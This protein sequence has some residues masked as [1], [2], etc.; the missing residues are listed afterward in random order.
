MSR[1]DFLKLLG[2]GAMIGVVGS[3]ARFPSNLARAQTPVNQFAGTWTDNITTTYPT[4]HTSILKNGKILYVAGTGWNANLFPGTGSGGPYRAGIVDPMANGGSGSEN[5]LPDQPDDL[6]CCG[7]AQ[8][9]NGKILIAG[10]TLEYDTNTIPPGNGQ[11]QGASYA[12]E[13]DPNNGPNG[14]LYKVPSMA[15][16]RWYP[17]MGTLPSGKVFCITGTDETGL[18]VNQLAEIY[19]PTFKSWNIK[20]DP[21]GGTYSVGGLTYT[22]VNPGGLSLYVR[23]I[24][25]PSGL[26]FAG[27]QNQQMYVWNASD[28]SLANIAPG[29][30]V[31]TVQMTPNE[32]KYGCAVLLPLQNTTAERGKVLLAG[33]RDKNNNVTNSVE[34]VDFSA[35]DTAPSLTTK[36]PLNHA[37]MYTLPVITPDGKI[38]I[39]GGTGP[40][41]NFSYVFTPEMYD[42]ATNT[43]NDLPNANSTT[44][45]GRTYHSVT[46]L[47]QDGS[48]WMSSGTP[49]VHEA[50]R[51]SQIF[52]PWYFTSEPR[53]TISA[54]PNDANAY[55]GTI[56][57]STPDAGSNLKVSL[58]RLPNTTHHQDA[59]HRM[60]WLIPLPNPPAGTV[61]V[62]APIN[63]NIAPPGY[64]YIHV[65]KQHS[66][67]P[68]AYIPSMAKIIHIGPMGVYQNV[69]APTIGILK[70]S[71]NGNIIGGQVTIEGTASS[72]NGNIAVVTITITPTSP[73]GTPP[74]PPNALNIDGDWSYWRT[75]T[76]LTPGHYTIKAVATD[77]NGNQTSTQISINVFP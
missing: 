2:G 66:T 52:K 35:S 49:S 57:I 30:W 32:R 6:F 55:G 12:Y 64:Y 69:S 73:V 3:F 15:H 70:P 77:N 39:F 14:T 31:K 41:D 36:T 24:I 28:I 21:T 56:S 45:Y 46:L 19:D 75:T 8:L 7:F 27:G 23:T 76:T 71:G 20:S 10:G 40:G 74:P 5:M 61:V 17:S 48:I 33:G 9:A 34:L 22:K 72:P 26:I 13:Y 68:T 58:I 42:P 65:L 53:P 43:W 44:A 59:E 62:N 16:G 51:I 4:I 37:R 11:N 67:D 38:I 25:M 50:H 63:A 60:I 18:S 1:R 54:Q 47:L 29:H